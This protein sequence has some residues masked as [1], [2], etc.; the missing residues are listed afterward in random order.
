[1]CAA[2]GD[3][4]LLERRCSGTGETDLRDGWLLTGDLATVD[5]DGYFQVIGRKRDTIVVGGQPV[6]PRDIEELLFEYPKVL[7]AAVVGIDDPLTGQRPK[8]FVVPSPDATPTEE[9][10]LDLC[11]RRLEPHAVPAEIELCDELPRSHI[12]KVNRRPGT[13]R[14]RGGPMSPRI[15]LCWAA[16]AAGGWRTSGVAGPV[17][18]AHPD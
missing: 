12:G 3:A 8:A 11:R 14:A 18:R 15:G 1:V 17:A 9:E 5:P 2:P 16:V 7:E 10:L 6:Y 4:R 13:T